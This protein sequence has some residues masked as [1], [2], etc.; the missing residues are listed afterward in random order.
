MTQAERYLLLALSLLVTRQRAR[1]R[2]ETAS[3][4]FDAVRRP[5]V[6]DF[7]PVGG[8]L[9]CALGGWSPDLF[10]SS[11]LVAE[12][13]EFV[14]PLSSLGAHAKLMHGKD[15]SEAKLSRDLIDWL[16]ITPADRVYAVYSPLHVFYTA[17]TGFFLP[18]REPWHAYAGRCVAVRVAAACQSSTDG[19]T[20]VDWTHG[21]F[22]AAERA[23]ALAVSYEDATLRF[24]LD[25]QSDGFELSASGRTGGNLIAALRKFCAAR[26]LPEGVSAAIDCSGDV[27]IQGAID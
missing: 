22:V 5:V 18:H 19:A 25:M 13:A 24:A 4:F 3:Y 21:W 1:V 23:G 27:R 16:G 14:A 8:I 9:R 10:F 15:R 17:D 2:G 12:G 6:F 20:R 7:T 11:V 26:P